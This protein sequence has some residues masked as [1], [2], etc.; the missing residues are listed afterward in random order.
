MQKT[1]TMV[2]DSLQRLAI[3]ESNVASDD[4]LNGL[5][6]DQALHATERWPY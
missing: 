4:M 2:A 1:L 5:G 6:H 3:F